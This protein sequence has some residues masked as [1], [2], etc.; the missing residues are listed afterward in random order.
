MPRSETAYAKLV[1]RFVADLASI[2]RVLVKDELKGAR[3]ARKIELAAAR[4]AERQAEREAAAAERAAAPKVSA[5]LQ[6]ALERAEEAR[7]RAAERRA[8]AIAARAARAEVRRPDSVTRAGRSSPATPADVVPPPLFVH[9]RSRD[10]S[11]QRLERGS[12]IPPPP[13]PA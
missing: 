10:G 13:P 12:E 7:K 5:R 6:R 1:D 2:A 3:A 8:Q 11:I 9:K 4:K